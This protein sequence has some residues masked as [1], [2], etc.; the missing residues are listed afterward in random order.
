V[1]KIL[2]LIFEKLYNK[3]GPQHW[4]PGEGLEIVLGAILTQ[5]TSW[6]NVERA[7]ENLR[8]R[9]C[10]DLSCLNNISIEELE[11]LIRPSGYYR[12]KAR[13][14]K[15]VISLLSKNPCPTREQ[16][17]KIRGIGPETADSILLYRFDIPIFVVDAYTLRILNRIGIFKGKN[18]TKCQK[19]F[20][21]NLPNDSKLYNEY[22]AL[23]VKLGKEYCLLKEPKCFQ[24]PLNTLC[25]YFIRIERRK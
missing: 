11:R 15:L 19:L 16:L 13:T 1:H 5:Q 4:W 8:N 10:M 21:D 20:M 3:F 14:I 23:L 24:C 7:L 12:Q 22:H 17:L 2:A 6:S 18:Y 25:Q 9:G